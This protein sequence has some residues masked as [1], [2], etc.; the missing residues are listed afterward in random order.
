MRLTETYAIGRISSS[1]LEQLAIKFV[2]T[3]TGVEIEKSSI[4][5]LDA[6]R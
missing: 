2:S 4:I 5:L 6:R 3:V 1:N